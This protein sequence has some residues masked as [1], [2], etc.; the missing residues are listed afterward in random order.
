M[1]V[2]GSIRN[3]YKHETTLEIFRIIDY[4][5]ICV[6]KSRDFKKRGRVRKLTHKTF[7]TKVY[8]IL[9]K[10]TEETDH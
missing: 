7:E 6:K 10:Y 4:Q 1:S 5:K 2:H 9:K 3:A 8:E